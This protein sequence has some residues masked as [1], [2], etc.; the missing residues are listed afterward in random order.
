MTTDR[1]TLW[2]ND[3]LFLSDTYQLVWFDETRDK[4]EHKHFSYQA[5]NDLLSIP[6]S[7]LSFV[8]NRLPMCINHKGAVYIKVGT[9]GDAYYQKFGDLEVSKFNDDFLPQDAHF[10]FN[11]V[12]IGDN[13]DVSK[14]EELASLKKKNEVLQSEVVT[15]REHSDA[16]IS[17]LKLDLVQ[18]KMNYSVK[19]E[20]GLVLGYGKA[21]GELTRTIVSIVKTN[22]VVLGERYVRDSHAWKQMGVLHNIKSGSR[23]VAYTFVEE[24]GVMYITYSI[25]KL[26]DMSVEEL[27]SS[28]AF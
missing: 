18:S 8:D 9:G 19:V 20:P 6:K 23:Y 16:I 22:L 5:S 2:P 14:T 4:V 17:K 24:S 12:V 11:N 15:S 28:V 27:L 21:G 25:G 7:F 26:R 13:D 10:V 3:Q 1:V